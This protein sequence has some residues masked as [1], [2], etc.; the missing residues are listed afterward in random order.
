MSFNNADA[1]LQFRVS[2]A[3]QLPNV[4]PKEVEQFA[5]IASPKDEQFML[6]VQ[7]MAARK[8]REI[9]MG[10]ELFRAQIANK[11][12]PDQDEEQAYPIPD[13]EDRM[14]PN[15]K[16]VIDGRANRSGVA[17]LYAASDIA[18]AISEIRPWNNVLIT[19]ST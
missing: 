6:Q 12:R 19:V 8:V 7:L 2:I 4:T 15:A 10:T 11:W 14:R 16:K 3:K 9:P 5:F 13:S 18:T 1:F 17:V